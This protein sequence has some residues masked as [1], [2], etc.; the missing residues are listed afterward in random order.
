MNGFGGV[1]AGG[2][3]ALGPLLAGYWMATTLSWGSNGSIIAFVGLGCLSLPMYLNL[4]FLEHP[5]EC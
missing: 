5:E 4:Q 2:A 1:G 3:K